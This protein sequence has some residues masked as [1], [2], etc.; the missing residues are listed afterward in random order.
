MRKCLITVFV[1]SVGL[2][3]AGCIPTGDEEPLRA[4]ITT[5]PSPPRGDPPLTVQFSAAQSTGKIDEYIWTFGDGTGAQG[6]VVQHTYSLPGN[7]EVTLRVVGPEGERTARVTVHVNSEPPV[8]EYFD[9]DRTVVEAN[10]EVDFYVNAYDPDG[11][12]RFLH[13]DFGNGE[14]ATIPANPSPTGMYQVHKTYQE[15]SLPPTYPVVLTVTVQV[16]DDNGDLSEPA[17]LTIQV[18]PPCPCD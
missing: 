2:F 3:L 18:L 4:V 16:E 6:R 14:T 17:A 13:F 8:I 7:Y 10:T 5:E 12:V 9:V 11:S 1:I 15:D